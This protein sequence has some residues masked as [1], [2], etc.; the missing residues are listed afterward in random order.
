[1]VRNVERYLKDNIDNNITIKPWKSLNELPLFLKKA[2]TF[3]EMEILSKT[4]ILLEVSDDMPGVEVLQK[5]IN[6]IAEITNQ[7]IVLYYKKMTQYRRK[8]LINNRIPFVIDD[9]QMYLPFLG[10]D[11]KQAPQFIEKSKG[12]FSASTQRAFLFFLYNKD[13][14]INTTE[15]AERMGITLMTASRNLNDLY[16]ASLMMYEVGGKTGRSKEYRR[17]SDPLYFKN[18][19]QYIKSPVKKVLYVTEVPE[20]TL[21]AGLLAL[22]ELSQLN[23]PG[24]LV[25]AMGMAQFNE[26]KIVIIRNSDIVKDQKGVELQI[27]NYDPKQFSDSN[28][29]DL[30]S[31]YASLRD[32]K[33]ERIELAL[34]KAMKGESWYTG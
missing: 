33:D 6:R 29:V 27:W 24:Q 20:G 11:L 30:L 12:K 17:I 19:S 34:E 1:M 23:P 31:L 13:L 32:E 21:D 15:F 2:Y 5:H 25:K 3:Y 18:G 7:P 8:S 4:C 10:I 14:V 28:Q 16:D 9:G 22:A 26:N